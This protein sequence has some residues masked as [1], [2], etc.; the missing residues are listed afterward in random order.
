MTGRKLLPLIERSEIRRVLS[1]ADLQ[2]QVMILLVP[3]PLPDA[4]TRAALR[5]ATFQNALDS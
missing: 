1:L 3:H 5:N 2:T 4:S